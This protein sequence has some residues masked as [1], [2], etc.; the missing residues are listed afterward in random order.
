MDIQEYFE[1]LKYWRVVRIDVPGKLEDHLDDLIEWLNGYDQYVLGIER[2]PKL[3][4]HIVIGHSEDFAGAQNGK[5]KTRVKNVF[6]VSKSEFST[7]SVRTS[8]RKSIMYSL[9]DLEEYYYKGFTEAFVT[10][11]RTQSTKKFK[12]QE[13]A[14]A[15]QRIEDGY[16]DD[17]YDE[18]DLINKFVEL[19]IKYGQKPNPR[20]EETWY[21]RHY[22]K[23]NPSKI[24]HYCNER[25][26]N[27][28]KQLGL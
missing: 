3:H 24:Y 4:L 25:I 13:F 21:M 6:E 11:C 8:I 10:A 5:L 28:N 23:K 20:A 9:K 7:S 2:H 18:E 17:K 26:D 19:K 14:D 16:Y 22:L 1:S 15:L 12:K 27:A